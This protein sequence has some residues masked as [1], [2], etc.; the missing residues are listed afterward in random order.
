MFSIIP[1][2]GA[3][4]AAVLAALAVAAPASAAAETPADRADRSA[5]PVHP[6]LL[7]EDLQLTGAVSRFIPVPTDEHCSEISELMTWCTTVIEFNRPITHDQDVRL[8]STSGYDVPVLPGI[9]STGVA[10]E[11]A[12][13]LDGESVTVWVDGAFAGTVDLPAPT[14]G[15][16]PLPIA[17]P[18]G[19]I[20]DI[21][22][23][24]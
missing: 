23:P 21:P 18:T 8:R 11:F 13:F 12:P 4:V 22:A 2:T 9:D 6:P 3:A 10:T 15:S 19:E 24:L 7:D 20:I 17:P 1:R 5:A 14:L 16:A